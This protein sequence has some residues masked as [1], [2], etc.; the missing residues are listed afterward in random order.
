MKMQNIQKKAQQGFTLIELMIVI[1]IIGILA[2]VAMPAY[3][4]YTNRA[5]VSEV[6]V[7]AAPAK[8]A[9][10]ETVSSIGALASV[11]VANSGYVFPG[12][13]DYVGAIAIMTEAF[14]WWQ[15]LGYLYV[16]NL[17]FVLPLFVVFAVIMNGHKIFE[18]KDL[19]ERGNKWMKLLM[20]IAQIV[21]GV[22]LLLI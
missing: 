13:T 3:Q 22:G 7:M 12:A 11:T 17:M 1:A 2:A 8:L 19:Q 10:T 21:I 18:A 5:K 16:Y 4:D 14:S 20:A 6:I 15:T 9:V